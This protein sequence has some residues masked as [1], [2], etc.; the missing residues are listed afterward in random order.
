L[1]LISV[2][3]EKVFG[4]QI[5]NKDVNQR[6]PTGVRE[7]KEQQNTVTRRGCGIDRTDETACLS[8]DCGSARAHVATMDAATQPFGLQIR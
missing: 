6:F 1:Y 2:G 8:S 4:L 7:V 5:A 3:N